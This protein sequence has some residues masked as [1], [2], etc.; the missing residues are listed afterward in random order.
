MRMDCCG[1][2]TV[3]VRMDYAKFGAEKTFFGDGAC[4]EIPNEPWPRRL[5]LNFGTFTLRWMAKRDA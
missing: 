5:A 3:S 1:D 2:Q 4:P